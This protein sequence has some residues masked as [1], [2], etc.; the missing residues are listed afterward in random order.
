MKQNLLK[1]ALGLL[2]F[3]LISFARPLSASA[4]DAISPTASQLKIKLDAVASSI[5]ADQID[6][7][8]IATSRIDE[9]S[10]MS[11][12]IDLNNT[13]SAF[14]SKASWYSVPSRTSRKVDVSPSPIISFK[15][16]WPPNFSTYSRMIDSGA[17]HLQIFVHLLKISLVAFVSYTAISIFFM[18]SLFS[19]VYAFLANA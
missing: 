9:A 11:L 18:L 19:R 8:M 5:T 15:R 7:A 12:I 16:D 3:S 10:F 1:C 13:V 6:L 2:I 4:Y 14:L 17:M